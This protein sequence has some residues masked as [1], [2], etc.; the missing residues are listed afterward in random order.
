MKNLGRNKINNMK[1]LI[2]ILLR[3]MTTPAV[4]VMFGITGVFKLWKYGG[5]INVN[6]RHE[7]TES[8]ALAV[9]QSAID[10]YT[11]LRRQFEN[12]DCEKRWENFGK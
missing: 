9:I 5:G 12:Q 3:I 11:L 10:E 6:Y 2:S 8:E 1:K 4:L 7:V